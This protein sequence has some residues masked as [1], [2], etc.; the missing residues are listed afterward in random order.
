MQKLTPNLQTKLI[1]IKPLGAKSLL[2]KSL[3]A[4]L[5]TI[6]LVQFTACGTILHPERKGQKSGRIDPAIAI[7][8]GI[9]LLF[10]LLPGVIAFAVDFS[11]GTIYLP[12]GRHSSLSEEEL[13][14]ITPHG[15]LDEAKLAEILR[16]RGILEQ[17]QGQNLQIQ[18]LGSL[19]ELHAHLAIY[20]A[21]FVQAD[22]GQLHR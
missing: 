8:D 12:G 18:Q 22:P 20:G 2:R 9:G 11:N 19:A 14:Q 15:K 1:R 17:H 6:L 16:V 10:F 7:L 3:I 13:R 5:T 4:T 21:S